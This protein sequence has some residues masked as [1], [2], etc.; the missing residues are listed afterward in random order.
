MDHL[1]NA[2]AIVADNGANESCST[3]VA[4]TACS[5]LPV[6]YE[7]KRLHEEHNSVEDAKTARKKMPKL[8]WR[9]DWSPKGKPAWF[10][11]AYEVALVGVGGVDGCMT[12]FWGGKAVRLKINAKVLSI[13]VR[14]IFGKRPAKANHVRIATLER[15]CVIHCDAHESRAGRGPVLLRENGDP[16]TASVSCGNVVCLSCGSTKRHLEARICQITKHR[17]YNPKAPGIDRNEKKYV[18]QWK[19]RM[20]GSSDAHTVDKLNIPRV[21][22]TKDINLVDRG[23]APAGGNGQVTSASGSV[24]CMMGSF[25]L[26][27]VLG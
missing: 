26:E 14:Q 21:I 8:G 5:A 20:R 16:P 2:V 18:K 25:H 12:R 6:A 10:L 15:M 24:P 7:T 1:L 22:R 13:K 9:L 23:D 17:K 11:Y 19:A 3:V 27:R 4:R